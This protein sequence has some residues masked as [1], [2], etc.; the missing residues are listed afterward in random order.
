LPQI[1]ERINA[2]FGYAAVGQVR[3]VQA[4]V[5]ARAASTRTEAALAP[6]DE[7]ALSARLDAVDDDRLR[8]ALD[9]LGRGVMGGRGAARRG[10]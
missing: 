9:R 4:P 8:A 3:I 1:V 5:T 10:R 2:F 7:A 6:S